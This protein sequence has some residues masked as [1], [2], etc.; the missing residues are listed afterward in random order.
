[1]CPLAQIINK[2][3]LLALGCTLF[4]QSIHA[5]TARDK[6]GRPIRI[7]LQLY[8]VRADCARDLPGVL[9]AVAKMG[10]TGV[11]FAGYH[12]RSAEELRRMLDENKLKCYGTHLDLNA[13]LGDKFEKTVA[14]CR[15]LGCK[16]L[17]VPW[18]P[19]E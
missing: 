4:S 10:Y 2:A 17:V 11:E 7:G 5:Q 18:L 15:V 6:S 14:F 8:S 12:G 1:M 19:E 9:K 13:L 3:A 16:L